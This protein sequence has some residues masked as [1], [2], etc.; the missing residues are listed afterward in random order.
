M[1]TRRDVEALPRKFQDL[2]HALSS[3]VPAD[4]LVTD[5]LRTLA[6]GTDASFY[7]LVPKIV[8]RVRSTEEVAR[9]LRE[10]SRLDLGCTFRAGGTS[11]SG[12][13]VSD[14]VLVQVTGGFRRAEVKEGGRSIALEPGVIGAEANALLAPL[15][16]KI[17]PDPA[18]IGAAMVGGI[19]ANNASGMCCGTSQNSYQTVQSVKILLAD[20]TALDTADAAS[21]AAF[22]KS[23]AALLDGLA[24]LRAKILADPPLAERIRL[25]YRI[26]NTTGYGLNSFVDF[27]DPFDILVHLLIG[28]EGTLAFISEITYRTVEEHAHKASA[29]LFFPDLD[30]A[31]RATQALKAGDVVSAAELMDRP[32]LRSVENKAGLPPILKTLPADACA[33]LVEVRAADPAALA[34]RMEAA[35]RLIAG[36]PTL[37]PVAFTAVKAEYETLWDVRKGLFPAV[38]GARR[39]GTTVVIEDVAFPIEHLAAATVELQGLFLEHGYSEGIIFGHALDGNVHFVFTQDFGDRAEVE[40]YERFMQAVCEMV[41]RKYGG[42]LKAEHGTGRNMAP[43]VALEWGEKGHAVM[44]RVKQLFDPKGILNPGVILNDDPKAHLANLKPLPATHDL[45][46]KC[47]ECG[48][49]EPKC[50]SRALTLTPRQRIT[51]QREITRLRTTGADPQRL[52]RIEEDFQYQ[53]LDTCAADGLCATACPVSIDTGKLTKALRA[54]ERGGFAKSLA[55]LVASHYEG[56]IAAAKAGF[57]FADAQHAVLGSK[58]LGAITGTAHRAT[59]GAAPAWNPHFPRP[60]RIGQLADVVKGEGRQVIYFPSCITRMWGPARGDEDQRAVSA[61]MLSVLDKAGYDVLFP[62]EMGSLCCGLTFES[63]GFPEL[64]DQKCAELERELM[65][66]SD[67]GKIPILCDT[68]PC[69]QRMRAHFPPELK[70]YEP[71]EFIHAFLMDKLTFEKKAGSVAVHVTCS[72]SKLG[73]GPKLEAVAKACAEKVVVP[74]TGCC[75]FAGDRGFEVPELNASALRDLREQV[76]GCEAGYSNSRGCEIG[77]SQHG[78]IPYQSI[79]YLVDRCTLPAHPRP[80]H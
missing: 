69:I 4:R 48:F 64:A 78:G 7:R 74:P 43:F 67:G 22:A 71:A 25:K 50:A 30:H 9:L 35:K 62:R 40:R 26:K 61:A 21:R 56:A 57:G 65:E 11:L 1:D 24:D 45:V 36:I 13:S 12:Q 39:V 63:K 31:A 6:F 60:A 80:S 66:R 29:L 44:R 19:A 46:D 76:K 28:S 27:E 54:Q 77:L 15:G 52:A 49:C 20:G 42:S 59:S 53:G 14:S 3:F 41:V 79:V 47:I 51:L 33:L 68:S 73:L 16:R 2:H 18:S 34:A 38:G 10:A 17:G 32:S 58:L 55:G 5:P 8:V 37:A 23:H 70:V 75:A 72:T